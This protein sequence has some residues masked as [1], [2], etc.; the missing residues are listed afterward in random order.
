MDGTGK[1]MCG[2]LLQG[3]NTLKKHFVIFCNKKGFKRYFIL[4]A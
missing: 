4:E 2:F 3:Q 1:Q